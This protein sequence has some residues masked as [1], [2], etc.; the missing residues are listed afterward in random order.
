MKVKT[1]DYLELLKRAFN[2][3]WRYRP[4]WI[5]GFFL[6]LCSGGGGG[7]GNFNFPGGGF[8]GNNEDGPSFP[9]IGDFNLD[10]NLLIG[11]GIALLCLVLLLILLSIIVPAITRTALI[12]MV[13][14]IVDWEAVTVRAGWQFG[15]SKRAWRLFLVSVV[16]G[17]PL[18]ILALI[19]LGIALLPLLLILT[20]ETASTVIGIILTV[21]AAIFIVLLLILVG[22]LLTPIFELAWR[23]TVLAERGVMDSLRD[24]LGLIRSHLKEVILLLLLMFGVGIGWLLISLMIVLPVMLVAAALIGGIPALLV[25]L[26]SNSGLGAAITGIPLALITLI[27]IGGA[28]Q[29]LYRIYQSAVWTLAYRELQRL[30]T[31]SPI[32]PESSIPETPEPQPD[33]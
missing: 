4:L 13:D 29:G 32:A 11:L 19:L 27:L 24:T 18:V 7:G 33:L 2:I 14:Q 10:P 16:V 23:R 21:F 1:M 6:A 15:W 26:I 17:L 22:F 30:E 20:Q 25:Y 12:G 31:I 3:T 9:E 5:F 28:A 8:N